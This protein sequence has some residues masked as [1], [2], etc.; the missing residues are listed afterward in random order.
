MNDI[1]N[2]ICVEKEFHD[3]INYQIELVSKLNCLN[4]IFLP[5]NQT[6]KENL[7]NLYQSMTKL[8]KNEIFLH[9]FKTNQVEKILI[10]L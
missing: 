4:N 10:K 7:T 1:N 5:F 3:E 6:N 9:N 8:I 2:N